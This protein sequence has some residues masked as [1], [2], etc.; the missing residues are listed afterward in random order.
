MCGWALFFSVVDTNEKL[1]QFPL[2]PLKITAVTFVLFQSI[3]KEKKTL[4]NGD[5]IIRCLSMLYTDKRERVASLK[6]RQASP[7]LH[8]WGI[9]ERE[10]HLAA[11][12]I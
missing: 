11:V 6:R 2:G 4:L 5:L 1:G 7:R 12:S 8:H 10:C 3:L 9:E